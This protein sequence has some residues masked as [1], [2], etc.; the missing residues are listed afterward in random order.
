M[1]AGFLEGEAAIL[2]KHAANTL[3]GYGESPATGHLEMGA[4]RN[5]RLVS[6]LP[7]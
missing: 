4:D 1:R 3:P 6:A 5:G 2:S 7:T